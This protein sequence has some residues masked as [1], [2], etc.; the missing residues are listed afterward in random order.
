MAFIIHGQCFFSYLF[1]HY[2]H[3]QFLKLLI[4][5][6]R[7]TA[8]CHTTGIS[9]KKSPQNTTLI[10]PNPSNGIVHVSNDSQRIKSI[11]LYNF[12]GV[13]IQEFF[14][15]DFSISNVTA[16]IYFIIIQTEKSTFINR[17]VKQ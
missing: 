6:F 7:R 15:N 11:K 16:G 5:I 10:Y 4:A 1:L 8:N 3:L 2:L 9:D 13:F 14:T 17:L 12:Q